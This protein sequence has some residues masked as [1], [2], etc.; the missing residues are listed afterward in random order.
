MY[1]GFDGLNNPEVMSTDSKISFKTTVWFWMVN[2]KSTHTAITSDQG[3]GG[4]IRAINIMECD[5][6]IDASV[7]SRVNYYQKFCQQSRSTQDRIFDAAEK[8]P[9]KNV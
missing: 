5:G 1:L 9:F 6:G 7:S 2:S 4:T 8:N 3:F